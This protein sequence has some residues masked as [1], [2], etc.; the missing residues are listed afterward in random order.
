MWHRDYL[1]QRPVYTPMH[2]RRCFRVPLRLFRLLEL[3]LPKQD[4]TFTQKVDGLGRSGATCWQKILMCLRRLG[5]GS[6]FSALDDQARMSIESMRQTFQRFNRA[7]KLCYGAKYLNRAH[8]LSELQTIE[9]FYSSK[10]FPGCVRAVDCMHL[11]WKNCPKALKGQL[12]NPKS[13]KLATL[14]VEAVCDSN[15]YCWN[16]FGGRPGTNNDLTVCENSPLFQ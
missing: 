7:M 12:H 16:V 10:R 11:H 13:G 3:D 15:L 4:A 1:S 9:S 14:Q 6:P 2:F 8:T 5:Y